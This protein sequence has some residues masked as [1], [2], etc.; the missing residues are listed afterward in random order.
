MKGLRSAL[1]NVK[2]GGSPGT[3]GLR[4][5]YLVTLAETLDEAQMGLLEE[6]G[7]RYLQGQLP[8][9]FYSVFLSSQAVALFKTV[10]QV[11]VRPIGV[12]H[13]LLRVLHSM[14]VKQNRAELLTYLEPEQQALSEAGCHKVVFMVRTLLE[15]NQNFICIKLDIEN[16]QNSMSRAKCVEQ[17]EAVPELRHLAWHAATALAPNTALHHRGEKIGEAREGFTQGDNLATPWYC[18]TWQPQVREAE[19]L[20]KPAGGAARFIS[21]DGYLTGPEDEV[22]QAFNTFKQEVWTKCGLQLQIS[23]CEVFSR[24]G[25]LPTR[26][27]PSCK[28]GGTETGIL[29]AQTGMRIPVWA[30]RILPS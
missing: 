11:A 14:V 12:R 7:L 6:F 23:K 2:K 22:I 16:A 19:E 30:R 13:S 21:D 29:L 3:G 25:V 1:L 5:E 26:V 18:T 17:L 20:L 28:W 8:N 9:W 15:E 10:E 27:P 4:A 24:N